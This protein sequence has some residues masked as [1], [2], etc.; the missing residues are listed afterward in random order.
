MRIRR[1]EHPLIY[2]INTRVW[3]HEFEKQ[4]RKEPF[5]ID[6]IPDSALDE[7]AD[8]GFDLVWLM[9]VW[10]TGE[11]GKTIARRYP[12]LQSECQRVLPGATSRDILSS[13]Y[14]VQDY[15][16]SSGLSGPKA[17]A[18]LRRRLAR[19]GIGLILDF[20]PNHTACDHPWIFSHPE[21]YVQGNEE[22]L[23]REPQN[24]F[25]AEAASGS[26]I[27]AHGRDPYFPAWSDTAQL[28]YRHRGM[29]TAMKNRL[30]EIAEQCDGIRCDMAMLVLKEVFARTWGER[31]DA[32]DTQA[33]DGEFWTEAIDRVRKRFPDFIFIAEAYWGL[34]RK[35]Q[36]LG[37]DYTY[38]KT[39]YDLLRDHATAEVREHLRTDAE[40]LAGSVHF[41]ENHDELRAAQVF[42]KDRHQAAAVICYTTPG[43]R[44]FHEGQLEGRKIR[45]PVQ[46]ARR[47][48]EPCN[49]QIRRFY[50]RLLQALQAPVFHGGA[51]KLLEAKPARPGDDGWRDILIFRWGGDAEDSRLAAVNYAPRH[52]RCHVPLDFPYPPC[53]NVLFTD[54]FSDL[55]FRRSG[56]SLRDQGLYLEMAPFQF[57]LFKLTFQTSDPPGE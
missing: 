15:Q 16:V 57:H 24:F 52:G 13:P 51:W 45:I 48:D 6:D 2:E 36:S 1:T 12:S 40:F 38:D 28:N 47:P 9:G 42:S 34:E 17:L 20:V 14:A 39:L 43:M 3:V 10:Q 26:K 31:V 30:I 11:L 4:T 41:L 53:G 55:S 7:I 46:L 37:F 35:L 25:Q 29:C 23:G 56:D 32:G 22:F 5:T 33:F 27:I 19:R 8:L 18:G 54:Q 50:E 49:P 44:F 21:Y